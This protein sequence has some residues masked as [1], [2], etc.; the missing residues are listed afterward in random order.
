MIAALD[1]RGLEPERR[2]HLMKRTRIGWRFLAVGIGVRAHR[3]G[4]GPK[5]RHD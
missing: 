1:L 3:C 4:I 2:S 5:H